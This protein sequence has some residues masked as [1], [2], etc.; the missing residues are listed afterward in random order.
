VTTRPDEPALAFPGGR[1][2]SEGG[3]PPFFEGVVPL[4]DV[5]L[6]LAEFAGVDP[7]AISE[8]TLR[9]DQSDSGA[10]FLADVALLRG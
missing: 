3:E 10:L 7:A 6:P 1:A 5:R 2:R 8:I 9:M 4:T